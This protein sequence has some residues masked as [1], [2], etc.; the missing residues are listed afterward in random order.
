MPDQVIQAT[1][2]RSGEPEPVGDEF[3]NPLSAEVISDP[4]PSYHRLR[5]HDPVY[6]HRQLQSWVLT[7][8]HDCQAVLRDSER[9]AADFRRVGIPTPPTLLSLQTLDPP[10]QTPLRHLGLA[11]LRAQD[12]GSLGRTFIERARR[13]LLELAERGH[14]D[15]VK[16]FSDRFTMDAITTLLG[17]AGPDEDATFHELNSD[18]DHSMDAGFAPGAEEA[19]IRARARFNELV[20]SWLDNPP[21]EGALAYLAAHQDEG[22]VSREVLVNSI[23]AFFHA[24]F[25]VPSR[26]L[27]NAMLGLLRQPAAYQ[28]LRAGTP[29]EP[30]VEELVRYSGPVHALSR[31]CTQDSVIGGKTIKRGQ[32]VVTLI[33]A[34]DRDPAQFTDPDILRLDRDPNPHLGFGRGSHSCLG[35]MVGR[36]EARA[37]LS[38]LVN[39]LPMLQLNGDPQHR[40][41]ATLRGLYRLPVAAAA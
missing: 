20:E 2:P 11:T 17:V 28:A 39:D 4:H 27:G 22:G 23:R 37:V 21:G 32:V 1:L 41:N 36:A 30:A 8:H 12:L 24:G 3:F 10:D 15:F 26:F 40:P 29:I 6:W 14:F 13:S 18:L 16:D 5:A 25:E 9:F 31:A 7:R 34:A 33:K 19:G 38:A 35:A